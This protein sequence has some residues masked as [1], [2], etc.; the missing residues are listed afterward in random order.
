ML[1]EFKAQDCF[2][3]QISDTTLVASELKIFLL[4]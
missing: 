1:S 3:T 4:Q 2:F